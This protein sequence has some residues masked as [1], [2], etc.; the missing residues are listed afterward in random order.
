MKCDRFASSMMTPRI[1]C[2][3]FAT[4]LL[5]YSSTCAAFKQ[6]S[7]YIAIKSRALQK[8]SCISYCRKFLYH[9]DGSRHNTLQMTN[10]DL[11]DDI[12]LQM[13]KEGKIKALWKKYGAFY[14]QVWFSIYLPF[15]LSFFFILDNKLL[16]SS[17][18][19]SVDPQTAV[20]KLFSWLDEVSNHSEVMTG[21][22]E[23]PRVTTFATAYLLADLVP[24]TFFALAAVTFIIKQRD[25]SGII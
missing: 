17:A 10:E 16:Q 19:A 1:L 2:A 4:A 25:K 11:D 23:N 9:D 12:Q 8:P 6:N 20:L 14:F 21:I 3:I 22:L 13:K 5:T 7:R 18:L 24:T 15:L